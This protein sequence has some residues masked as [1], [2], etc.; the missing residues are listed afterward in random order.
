MKKLALIVGHDKKS[1]GAASHKVLN[2]S[3]YAY[4][5][6]I[7]AIA[8]K[9]ASKKCHVYV[10]LRDYIGIEGAYE[11]AK[12]YG[13]DACIELHF[14]AYDGSVEGTEIL[15]HDDR[16]KDPELEKRF[17]EQVLDKMYE[18]FDRGRSGKR[19]KKEPQTRNER[20]WYNVSRVQAFPCVLVEPFF[21]DNQDDAEKASKRKQVYAY[22]LIDAF[23][24]V[25]EANAQAPKPELKY[26]PAES[27]RYA[28]AKQ[29]DIA[30][31]KPKKK[32]KGRRKNR[33]G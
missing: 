18:V 28:V 15:Y 23:M 1:Q 24:E 17:A 16:D 22:G 13:V 25:F 27:E 32:R 8:Q 9:Y 7:A 33:K 31:T 20:G 26:E 21:G 30:E 4:N 14:N 6:E 19:G 10:I 2:R 11:K 12:G 29:P 5:R 3:E